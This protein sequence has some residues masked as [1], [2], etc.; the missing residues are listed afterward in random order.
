MHFVSERLHSLQHGR[1]ENPHLLMELDVELITHEF[2]QS[3]LYF[4]LKGSTWGSWDSL[5]S[6]QRQRFET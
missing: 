3:T 4:I 1:F 2:F 6:L 5:K